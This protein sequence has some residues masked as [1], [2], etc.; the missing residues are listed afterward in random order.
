VSIDGVDSVD[1]LTAGGPA[2][3][4]LVFTTHGFPVAGSSMEKFWADYKAKYNADPESVFAATGYDLV[5]VIEAAVKKA[6][7]TDP[8]KV[9]DAI[10]E[11]ENVQGAT[12]MITY[13]GANR[14]PIKEVYLVTV[15]NGKFEF[16]EKVTPPASLI[17]PP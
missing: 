10:N 6:G 7:S 9:R 15:K 8:K 3:E 1:T 17:P 12:G 13:K 16:I 14:I 11:L 5:K 4:G 2:V